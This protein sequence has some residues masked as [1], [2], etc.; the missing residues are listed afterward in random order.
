MNTTTE[1]NRPC[2]H[3]AHML[4]F[5]NTLSCAYTTQT[6]DDFTI[7]KD[8]ALYVRAA[9]AMRMRTPRAYK[10]HKKNDTYA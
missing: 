9:A 7:E 1:L 5:A 3:I 4:A 10:L 6:N 2:A 8:N